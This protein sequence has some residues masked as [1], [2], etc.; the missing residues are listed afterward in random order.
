MDLGKSFLDG[1]PKILTAIILII[2]GLIVARVVSNVLKKALHK[3]GIDKLGE[4]LNKIEMVNKSSI[5][6]KITQVL[7]KIVYYI[8][9]L[10]FLIAATSALEMPAVSNLMKDI[11]T[12]IPNIIVA[13]IILVIGFIFAEMMKTVA[14][15]ALSSFGVPS[16][17]MIS[18]FIF[19]FLLI[20]IIVSALGQAAI[21]TEF[22]SQNISILIAGIVLAFAIGYGLAS[23]NTM[24][25]FIGS[26]YTK[27]RIKVGDTV[28]LDGVEGKILEIDRSVLTIL[29]KSESKVYVPLSKLTSEKLEKLN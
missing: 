7:S 17:R 26:M 2:I 21:E 8:I 25:N 3:I 15:T 10:F 6:I 13:G 16:A 29:T 18:S 11:L 28:R 23:Q 20:N 12:F 24:A 5:E 9:F 27:N 1:V 19:Y 14:H 4:K 22:L